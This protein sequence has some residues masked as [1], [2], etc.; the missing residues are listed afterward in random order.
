M[1]KNNN[2]WKHQNHNIGIKKLNEKIILIF[3]SF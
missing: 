2:I 1:S 3:D